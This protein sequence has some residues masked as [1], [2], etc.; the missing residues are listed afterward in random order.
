METTPYPIQFSV[1]YP[2]RALSR[3]TTF[4]R[5]FAAIPILF[6]LGAVSGATWEWTSEGRTTAAGAG[7]L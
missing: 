2:D 4:F 3:L 5:L 7:G 6:V 1:D